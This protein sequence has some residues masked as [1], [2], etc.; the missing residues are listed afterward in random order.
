MK[1]TRE[2][3]V[4]RDLMSKTTTNTFEEWKKCVCCNQYV[5]HEPMF[6]CNFSF[7]ED[8][9]VC[10]EC[11]HTTLDAAVRII[12]YTTE[13]IGLGPERLSAAYTRLLEE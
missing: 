11:A 4:L 8:Y 13:Y 6:Y 1:I 2:E 10:T 5:K 7:G 12:N 9:F 3:F